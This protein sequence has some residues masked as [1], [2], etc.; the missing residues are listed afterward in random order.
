MSLLK[1]LISKNRKNI[2]YLFLFILIS[3]SKHVYSFDPEFTDDHVKSVFFS[4]KGQLI[5]EPLY[6]LGSEESIELNWDLLQEN[7]EPLMY[8]ISNLNFDFTEGNQFFMDYAEGFDSNPVTQYAF[9][10]ATSFEYTHYTL[11]I[12]NSDFRFK[13]PGAYLLSIFSSKKPE[14]IILKRVVLVYDEQCLINTKF[15]KIKTGDQYGDQ[16]HIDIELHP[17][18]RVIGNPADQIKLVITQNYRLDNAI[19]GPEPSHIVNN[20]LHYSDLDYLNFECGNEYR[21]FEFKTISYESE[22]INYIEDKGGIKHIYL[23]TDI[24]YT[25]DSYRKLADING[26]FYIANDRGYNKNVDADYAWVYFQLKYPEPVADGN[27]YLLGQLA[28]NKLLD[29][30]RMVYNIE[31]RYYQCKMLLKQGLYNY[32]YV[33]K[34]KGGNSSLKLIEGNH[35]QTENDYSIFVYYCPTNG[36]Q[37][38]LVGYSTINSLTNK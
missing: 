38:L 6:F 15:T 13:Q 11:S 23:K 19:I 2:Q 34:S 12:P 9:S 21:Y 16:H 33:F 10:K 22:E 26:N 32:M 30:N 36:N 3:F 37:H 35:F 4:K 8:Q 20:V 31:E 17:Q 14:I 27:I 7:Y 24:D 25:F 18:Y 1:I 28:Y 29:N 5:A